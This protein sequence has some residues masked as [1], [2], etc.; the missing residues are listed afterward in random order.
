MKC[1][2]E[3]LETHPYFNYAD[4]IVHLLTMYLDNPDEEVRKIVEE[5]YKRIFH[6]DKRGFI[7]LVVRT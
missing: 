6:Q 5:C 1:L 4:N 3:L 7:S 2:S